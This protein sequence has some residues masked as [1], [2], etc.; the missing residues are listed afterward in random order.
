[1]G[2]LHPF[3]PIRSKHSA[4]QF[5][6]HP[7]LTCGP[8][9]SSDYR[10]FRVACVSLLHGTHRANSQTAARLRLPRAPPA[11]RMLRRTMDSGFCCAIPHSTSSTNTGFHD[12]VRACPFSSLPPLSAN[13]CAAAT[14]T[15]NSPPPVKL[16]TVG[17]L[18]LV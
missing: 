18:P 6:S 17:Y 10:F 16:I 8:P 1:L 7:E 11:P 4:A 9:L 13:T 12:L 2:Q 14:H 3:R 15:D 5:S